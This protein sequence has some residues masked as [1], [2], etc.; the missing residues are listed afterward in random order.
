MNKLLGSELGNFLGFNPLDAP[1]EFLNE[2]KKTEEKKKEIAVAVAKLVE[3]PEW[4]IFIGELDRLEKLID[5]DC[6]Y[7]ATNPDQ[8]KIDS[9]F[10]IVLELIKSFIA[11]QLKL[12]EQYAKENQEKSSEKES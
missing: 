5:R 11:N 9:G 10:K 6:H 8:A 4:P 7:Y 12:I 1:E 2:V 3:Y